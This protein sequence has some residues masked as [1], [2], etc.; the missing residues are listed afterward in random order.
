M[1]AS[2]TTKPQWGDEIPIQSISISKNSDDLEATFYY[3]ASGEFPSSKKNKNLDPD[4]I[5]ERTVEDLSELEKVPPG[6]VA[7]FWVRIIEGELGTV[8][9][10]PVMVAKGAHPGPVFGLTAALHGD[11][12][13]GAPTIHT[14]FRCIRPALADLHGTLVGVPCANVPGFIRRQRCFSDGQDL[15]RIMPGKEFGTASQ[16]YAWHFIERIIKK[17][18]YLIDLHTASKGRVNSFY[19]RADMTNDVVAGLANAF[20]ADIIVSNRT[21]ITLRGCAT[22]LGI[23]TICVEIGNSLQFNQVFI[24]QAINGVLRV[25]EHTK[26]I[27][28]DKIDLEKEL[29]IKKPKSIL[30]GR[31]YWIY[32]QHGGLLKVHP[33]LKE[34]VEKGQIIASV[35]NI[36]GVVTAE[37]P[38]PESGVIVGK[39][40]N[41]IAA[42][43]DR[44]AH[45]GMEQSAAEIMSNASVGDDDSSAQCAD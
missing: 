5:F 19:I 16:Q 43:G 2:S 23:P 27:S 17:F 39:A 8:I 30:C 9:R 31:S 4:T 11:E 28:R 37:Y 15:N 10:V 20:G 18:D 42:Q 21:K 38:A 32:T 7:H 12:I 45:I 24:K 36:F 3:V 13:Q 29:H 33:E 41:P 14:V 40:E 6:K 44:I 1:S 22:Q 34:R 26:L 35:V 25:L